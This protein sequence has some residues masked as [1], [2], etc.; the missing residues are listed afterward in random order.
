MSTAFLTPG[1]P[2]AAAPYSV[3]LPKNTNCAPQRNQD[4][5][6][7]P[8]AA[9]QH[10]RHSFANRSLDRR[11]YVERGRS[12]VELASAMVG[13]NDPVAADLSGTQC[14]SWIHNPFDDQR[15]RERPPIVL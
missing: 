9:V 4:V 11:Q 3:G 8:H 12:L 1:S 2:P 15:A 7:A 10:Y 6:A 14:I 13:H 5:A